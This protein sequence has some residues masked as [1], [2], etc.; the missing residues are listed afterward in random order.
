MDDQ[1]SHREGDLHAIHEDS[2][3]QPKILAEE[4]RASF[5]VRKEP[6]QTKPLL[7]SDSC[8]TPT[9]RRLDRQL[10]PRLFEHAKLLKG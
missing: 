6:D 9:T 10:T 2:E 3:P 4:L 8:L 7:E 5:G 1:F